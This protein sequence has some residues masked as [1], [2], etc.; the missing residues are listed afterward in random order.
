MRTLSVNIDHIATLR[1]ARQESFPDPVQAA[2]L[3]ELGGADGITVHLRKDRRHISDRDVKLLKATIKTELN[4]ELA[5]TPEMLKIALAVEPAQVSLV[6]ESPNEVT[7]QGGLDLVRNRARLA[8]VVRSLKRAGIRVS[9]FIEADPDQIS[10]AADLGCRLIEINTDRY[11]RESR[12]RN[13][14]VQ[15]LQGA[16][17]SAKDMGLDVHAGHGIDYRNIIGLLGVPEI[18]GVSIGFAIVARA[19]FTGLSEAVHEMK[20]MME[21]YS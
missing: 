7:T 19:V 5:A 16:A 21:V 18:T 20:R 3:A 17:L 2:V 10:C 9:S 8:P 12:R 4:L 6:P 14:I 1:Q 15:A 13:E 11:S